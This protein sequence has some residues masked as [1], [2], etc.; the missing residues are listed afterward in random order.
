VE[1]AI[2]LPTQ[3]AQVLDIVYC[4]LVISI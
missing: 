4:S 1:N 3:H 2:T